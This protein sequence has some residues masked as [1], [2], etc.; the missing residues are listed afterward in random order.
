PGADR[1][2]RRATGKVSDPFA[3][4]GG[5][6][7]VA[8]SKQRGVTQDAGGSGRRTVRESRHGCAGSSWGHWYHSTRHSRTPLEKPGWRRASI[9]SA[10]ASTG[11]NVTRLKPP[12]SVGYASAGN[13]FHSPPIR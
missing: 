5:P 6:H 9:R 7:R 4:A 3:A 12:F 10:S 1:S 11:S 8:R 13:G 2:G